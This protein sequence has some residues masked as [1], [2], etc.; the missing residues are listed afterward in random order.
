VF[1]LETR[2]K[3]PGGRR[4]RLSTAGETTQQ[5]QALDWQR[6]GFWL[7][8]NL[9]THFEGRLASQLSPNEIARLFNTVGDVPD[10]GPSWNV[11]S[12]K[13]R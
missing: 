13:P 7:R 1:F 12:R 5:N 4:A 2:S 9:E 3:H 10:L 8:I 6:G 11:A